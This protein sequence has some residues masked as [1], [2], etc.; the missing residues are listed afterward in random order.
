MTDMK[1]APCAFRRATDHNRMRAPGAMALGAIIAA[2]PAAAQTSLPAV[3]LGDST[4]QDGVAGPGRMVQVSV[5]RQSAD[6][7]RDEFGDVQT[8]PRRVRS[9]AI[10]VQASWL[11]ERRV[12]GAWWGAEVILPVVHVDLDL[13]SSPSQSALA[14]GDLF[15][16]P[17][18]LQWPQTTLLG[19]PYWQRLNINATL[20]TGDYGSNRLSVGANAWRFNPHYAFTWEAH[21]DWELSG[22][23]H[24]L[25]TSRNDEP[26]ASAN[27]RSVQ[28]GDAV[29]LNLAVSRRW[30]ETGRVG[31][32]GYRLAQIGDDRIDG[33]RSSGREKILGLGP[34]VSRKTGAQTWHGA[35]HWETSARDRP[36]GVRASV[37]YARTF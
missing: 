35:V 20:P 10:L 22:R 30:G 6:R 2:A 15:V 18:L 31:L 16:S 28:P 34:A 36:E 33:H 17:I 19:R 5:S 9:T 14:A 11:S 12:L 7:F 23:L 32:S 27:A 3:N 37:R 29:H 4:F 24:Y 8:A 1:N 21:D 26:P 13:G 25:W